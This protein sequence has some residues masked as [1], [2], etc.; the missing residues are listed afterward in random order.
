MRP[1]HTLHPV[2]KKWAQGP[3]QKLTKSTSSIAANLKTASHLKTLSSACKKG[4]DGAL[5]KTLVAG[6]GFKTYD[7]RLLLNNRARYAQSSGRTTRFFN[8]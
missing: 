6:E 3:L 7:L 2:N 5:I 4:P 1:R 8:N